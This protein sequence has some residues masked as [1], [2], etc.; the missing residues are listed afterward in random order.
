MLT[1][2]PGVRPKA[3]SKALPEAAQTFAQILNR[4]GGHAPALWV[5]RVIAF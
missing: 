1:G 4:P 2:I 5:K 3:L